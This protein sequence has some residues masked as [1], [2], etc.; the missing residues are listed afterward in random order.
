MNRLSNITSRILFALAFALA[1]LAVLE[2]LTNLIGYR[3][4]FLQGYAPFRLLELAVV[5]LVF[6]IALQLRELKQGESGGT[7]AADG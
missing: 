5:A 1:G 7:G 6:V 2:K 3:L 4:T